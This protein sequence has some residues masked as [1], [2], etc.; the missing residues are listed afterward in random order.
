[1]G[2]LAAGGMG[3]VHRARD[4]R[5]GREAAH[6][7][8]VVHRDLKP[9]PGGHDDG[10]EGDPRVAGPAAVTTT[11]ALS[12]K[13]RSRASPTATPTERHDRPMTGFTIEGF[14]AACKADMA[15][16]AD[17]H[18]AAS[19]HLRR[20]LADHSPAAIV[21]VLE[22]SIPAG[23]DIGEMIV[24][25]S[26]ELTMLYGRLPRH[27]QTGIHDHTVFACIGQL[28]GQERNVFYVR[29]ERAGLR[30]T[31]EVTTYPSEVIDLG[32]EAIHHVE[33]PTGEKSRAL[34]V[35]GGDFQAV[36]HRRRLWGSIEFDEKAF[37][38]PALLRE[39]AIKMVADENREGL[40]AMVEAIPAARAI[41]DELSA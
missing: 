8:D 35:Y 5:L 23:A 18:D 27:F 3:E 37:S 38:F 4:T 25:Q 20:T 17:P 11:R 6:E 31:G 33:N 2:P 34:H 1:M 15:A 19:Q 32:V 9:A 41:V 29:D 39:S 21:A 30:I 36:Q 22:A 10:A 40:E 14:A 24:H 16:A 13:A 12:S 26:D 28:T 7:A